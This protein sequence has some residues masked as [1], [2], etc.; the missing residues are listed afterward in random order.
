MENRARRFEIGVM[1]KRKKAVLSV[2]ES[3]VKQRV[4]FPSITTAEMKK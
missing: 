2:R 1:D 4:L 3:S